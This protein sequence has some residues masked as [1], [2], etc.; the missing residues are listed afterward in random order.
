MD[1]YLSQVLVA[2]DVLVILT[3]LQLVRPDVLPQAADDDGPS[4]CVHAE[5]PCQ[6]R[7]QLELH[8]LQTT[9]MAL[10]IVIQQQ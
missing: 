8:R 1:G 6:A 5:Q 4:L 10:N 7:V 9:T 3:V 2:V